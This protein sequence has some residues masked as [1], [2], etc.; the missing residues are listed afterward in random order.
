MIAVKNY[1]NDFLHLLFPHTC[2]GCNTDVLNNDAV[3]CAECLNSLPETG[4]LSAAG[5]P[6]EKIFYGRIPVEKAGSAFYFNKDSVLQNIIIQLKYKS[7][8]Q[9]G[10]FLGKL[11]GYQ[12]INSKRFDDVDIIIPLPL[13]ERKLYKRG[14]NQSLAIVKGITS[15]WH[16]PVVTNAVERIS[17]TETQTHKTRIARWQTMEGVFK[18]SQP[19]LIENKHVLLIDDVVTT[20]ATLEACSAAILKITSVKLSVATVAYTI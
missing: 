7:N 3:L 2:I 13:N 12:L 18:V 1:I 16:K 17:F 5:N 6:V 9:A 15:V 20:G 11:L 8:Q 4:F 19:A 10:I 14:Y